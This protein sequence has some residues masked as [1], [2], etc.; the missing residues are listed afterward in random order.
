MSFADAFAF[1]VGEEGGLSMD[2]KDPGN[3]T[4]GKVGIGV[5]KGTKYG[6]SAAQY[7]SLDI[8]NLTLDQ[9]QGIYKPDYWD[10]VSGDLIPDAI[11]GAL[12][13]TAVNEG[14]ATAIHAAQKAL[15]IPA[16]GVAGPQTIAAL[17]AVSISK[18]ARAFAIFRI[19]Q[20]STMQ[21]W[22]EDHDGWV[23]RVIDLYARM[24][25]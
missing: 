20:Y 25:K 2:P 1:T 5:L 14:P 18:F 17:N 3:W 7:P 8:A 10:K 6:I 15:G 23:G 13:D 19:V 4:G 22:S 24:V 16:D 11:A 9:A 12:F 21:L